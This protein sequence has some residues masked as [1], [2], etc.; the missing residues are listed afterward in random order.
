MSE[1]DLGETLNPKKELTEKKRRG[2]VLNVFGLP[3]REKNLAAG[4]SEGK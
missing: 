4:K 3:W 2:I 1:I